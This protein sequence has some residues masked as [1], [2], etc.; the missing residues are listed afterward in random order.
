MTMIVPSLCATKLYCTQTFI[1]TTVPYHTIV[2]YDHLMLVCKSSDYLRAL[3]R[4]HCA[5]RQAQPRLWTIRGRAWAAHPCAQAHA[6]AQGWARAAGTPAH[7]A[8]G[9]RSGP[10]PALR[11][12]PARRCAAGLRET[13]GVCVALNDCKVINKSLSRW[14]LCCSSLTITD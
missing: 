2:P 10:R 9:A 5:G 7:A 3:C 13:R 12:V 11:P 4:C 8:H 1:T 6:Q 14:Y